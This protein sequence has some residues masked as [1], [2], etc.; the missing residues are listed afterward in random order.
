MISKKRLFKFPRYWFHISTTLYDDVIHL[1]PSDNDTG[2]SMEEPPGARICVAPTI[3]QCF[4]AVA[5]GSYSIYNIY[6]TQKR[7]KVIRPLK[8]SVFDAHLTD[9]GWLEKPT[10]FVKYGVF[11]LEDFEEALQKKDKSIISE[12]AS[13]GCLEYSKEVRRWWKRVKFKQYIKRT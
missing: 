10:T 7:V 4:L 8:D 6:R 9:E 3:E 2:R 13:A 1:I 12:A 5:Y 11:P